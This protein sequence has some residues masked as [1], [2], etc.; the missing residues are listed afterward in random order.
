MNRREFIAG[1]AV[2]ASSPGILVPAAP[3]APVQ[4]SG[5][6][7]FQDAAGT[8]PVTGVNQ[9]VGFMRSLGGNG[10]ASLV[11]TTDSRPTFGLHRGKRCIMADGEAEVQMV[12]NHAEHSSSPLKFPTAPPNSH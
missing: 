7:L 9:P 10:I 1:A 11:A 4:W 5:F 8:I 2:C 3:A 12:I 6:E